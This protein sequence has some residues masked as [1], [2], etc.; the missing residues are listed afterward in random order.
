MKKEEKENEKIFGKE[1]MV[2]DVNIINWRLFN[3]NFN[4]FFIYIE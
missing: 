1:Y 3:G 2:Y 4:V